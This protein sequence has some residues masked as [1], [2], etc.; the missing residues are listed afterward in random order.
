[1]FVGLFTAWD[2]AIGSI[3]PIFP[4][5]LTWYFPEYER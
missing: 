1:L 5:N 4:E 2:T 3:D